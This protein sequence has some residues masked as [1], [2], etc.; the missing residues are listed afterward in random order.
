MS[1]YT[2]DDAYAVLCVWLQ[3]CWQ[4]SDVMLAK[5]A[6]QHANFTNALHV[7]ELDSRLDISNTLWQEDGGMTL[8]T[9]ALPVDKP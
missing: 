5:H 3:Q 6:F 8:S 7:Y 9:H 2:C 4:V 1:I